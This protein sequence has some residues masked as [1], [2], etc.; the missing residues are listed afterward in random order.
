MLSEKEWESFLT[1]IDLGDGD[2]DEHIGQWGLQV[3]A[4]AIAEKLREGVVYD[5]ALPATHLNYV[6]KREGPATEL[7]DGDFWWAIL[8]GTKCEDGKTYRVIVREED[9]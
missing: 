4:G 3:V 1:N 7:G 6:G 2:L 8:H 5:F 9:G